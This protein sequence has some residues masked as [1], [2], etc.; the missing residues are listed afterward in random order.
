MTLSITSVTVTFGAYITGVFGMNLDQTIYLQPIPGVFA[1]VFAVTFGIIIFGSMGI[2]LYFVRI[3]VIH[4]D[5]NKA[6]KKLFKV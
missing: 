6:E 2:Y 3:G 1:L 5:D 4:I